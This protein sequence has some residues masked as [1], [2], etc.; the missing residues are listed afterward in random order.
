MLVFYV[1]YK[2]T[3]YVKNSKMSFTESTQV[4]NIYVIFL[5]GYLDD[6]FSIH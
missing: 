6:T 4:K 2:Y 3:V 5:H 1:K